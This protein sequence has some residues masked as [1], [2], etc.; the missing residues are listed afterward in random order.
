[1]DDMIGIGE[2]LKSKV[3][4]KAYDDF[5][6]KPAKQ[7]GEFAEDLVKAIRL[8]SF[9]VQ[10]AA[11]VQDKYKRMLASAFDAVPQERRIDLQ[12]QTISSILQ[13]AGPIYER[14]KY[15]DENSI[16]Y[17]LF[18]ELLARSI[19]NKRNPEAQP[20]FIYIISQLSRDE[21]VI[22][23][24]LRNNDFDHCISF[25]IESETNRVVNQKIDYCNFPV[26]KLSFAENFEIY[27]DHLETLGL[28]GQSMIEDD[29]IKDEH[30]QQT[31]NKQSFKIHLTDFGRF[32][33][34]ACVPEK[35]FRN[36]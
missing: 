33:V 23:L 9:P 28:I 35:G 27:W 2:A 8:L 21:A 12:P 26:Y 31:G 11:A 34:H 22:L 29:L 15:M 6:S 1:M 4:E 13:I 10:Y 30:N 19:D 3:A 20:S 5:L 36:K 7:A 32:F 16:L 14:I 25:D 24:E 17:E 18:E